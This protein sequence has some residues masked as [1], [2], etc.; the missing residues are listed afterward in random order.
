MTTLGGIIALPDGSTVKGNVSFTDRIARIEESSSAGHDCIL[1]GL[2]DLQV[3]GSDGFDVMRATPESLLE[4]GRLL[5][6]EGTTAWLPTAVTAPIEQIARSHDAIAEATELSRASGSQSAAILG[7]HLEGP[8]IS[9]LRLGAHPKLNLEPRGDSFESVLAMQSLKLITLAPEIPGA[10]D[11]IGRLV[12]RGVIVSI[13]HTNATLEEANAGIAAGARMFTHLYNAMRPLNHRDPGV[14]ASALAPSPA[15]AAL[16][17]DGVHVHPEMLRLAWRARGKS[18]MLIVTD[19]VLLA[20][21]VANPGG[22]VGRG[23]ASIRDG[24]VRLADGT[25]AG[26]IISMLDGVR[27]MIDKVGVTIGDAAMLAATNPANLLGAIDRGRIQ[28]DARA[29]LIVLSRALELKAVFL[30][31]RELA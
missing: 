23:R 9:P 3:N 7:M 19:K 4:L 25:L 24:A 12:A 17:P 22:S 21:A 29:D 18:G 14:I 28:L 6:R 2:I 10:L 8:F 16:I 1:P 5:A 15:F 20:N 31:G 27:L 13:G 26:S 30:G 11:A